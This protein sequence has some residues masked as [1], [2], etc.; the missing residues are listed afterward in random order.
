V[1]AGILVQ[2][3]ARSLLKSPR[4][5]RSSALAWSLVREGLCHV[6]ASDAH[7]GAAWRPPEL[8]PA[9]AAAAREVGARAEWMSG[10][11]PAA[12][13]AGAPLPEPPRVT[14]APRGLARLR[15][16]AAA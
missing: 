15:R 12:V 16:R 10:A 8:T 5:S 14:A 3:T 11:A 4:R 7:S 13:L 1:A 9:V 6:L 2:V